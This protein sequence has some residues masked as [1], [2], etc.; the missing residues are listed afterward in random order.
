M[1]LFRYPLTHENEGGSHRTQKHKDPSLYFP[2]ILISRGHFQKVD[3]RGREGFYIE[4]EFSL[5][6]KKK[7]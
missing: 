4:N 1:H 2:C 5:E 7:S 6:Q 3:T